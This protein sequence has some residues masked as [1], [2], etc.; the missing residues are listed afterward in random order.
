LLQ[1]G[2]IGVGVFPE[3]EEILIGGAASPCISF[4]FD[5]M[6]SLAFMGDYPSFVG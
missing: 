2:D 5:V 6:L 3:G 4:L 1:D